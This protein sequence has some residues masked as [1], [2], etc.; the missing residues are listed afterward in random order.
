MNNPVNPLSKNPLVAQKKDIEETFKKM[1]GQFMQALPKHINFNRFMRVA[2]NAVTNT[3][4]LLECNR[5]SFFLAVMRAAQLGLEPDGLLGQAYLIPY[6]KM[7]QLIIGY[8]GYITL[9]R[10]SGEI[11]NIAVATVHENDDFELSFF[12]MPRFNRCVRGDRGALIGFIAKAE[13]KETGAL[14]QV[15]YMTVDEVNKIRDKHSKSKNVWAE[16]Y[17]EMGKKTVIRRLVKYLPLS[18][19]KAEKMESLQEA[20][21]SFELKEGDIVLDDM[22]DI[23]PQEDVVDIHTAPEPITPPPTPQ[24]APVATPQ[25]AAPQP[26][27]KPQQAPMD[28]GLGETMDDLLPM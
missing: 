3:P 21:V 8:K 17:E 22:Q 14:P 24:P 15:E 20:G 18:V 9:A 26:Q 2:L 28:Y 19:Q 7:A 27:A 13:F 1:E 6:G 11:A 25:P 12:G 5:K 10:Q 23:T 4:K 16:H